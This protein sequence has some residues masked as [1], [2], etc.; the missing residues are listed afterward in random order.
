MIDVCVTGDARI[1]DVC[2]AWRLEH[3][4]QHHTALLPWALSA[5]TESRNSVTKIKPNIPHSASHVARLSVRLTCMHMVR[6]YEARTI[7]T[8]CSEIGRIGVSRY[9]GFPH[10]I[11]SLHISLAALISVNQFTQAM[12]ECIIFK[13]SSYKLTFGFVRSPSRFALRHA[14]GQFPF[15]LSRQDVATRDRVYIGPF[16]FM[17]TLSAIKHAQKRLNSKPYDKNPL[18]RRFAQPQRAGG[19]R[20]RGLERARGIT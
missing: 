18:L 1:L 5:T 13:P 14:L 19:E 16:T 2:P 8:S 4:F 15:N 6:L 12:Y 17:Y 10:G 9:H 3:S 20:V 11:G 7:E